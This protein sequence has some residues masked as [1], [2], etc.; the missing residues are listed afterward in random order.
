MSRRGHIRFM[1]PLLYPEY[2]ALQK[3]GAVVIADSGRIQEETTF[4]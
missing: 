1:A 3:H 4:L 2:L